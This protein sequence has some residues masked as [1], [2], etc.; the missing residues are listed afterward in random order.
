MLRIRIQ[1]PLRL[2]ES[3]AMANRGEDVVQSV[4][5][6][7]GVE[8]LV[9][10]DQWRIMSVGKVEQSLV[11]GAVVRREVIVQ[12]DEDPVASENLLVE[13]QPVFG[14]SNQHGQVSA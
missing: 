5:V 2:V 13:G 10:D 6:G 7:S 11:A 8:N 12:L 14:V 3:R 1:I 9:G 4:A